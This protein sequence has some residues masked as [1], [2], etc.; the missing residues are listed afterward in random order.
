MF[1]AYMQTLNSF[2]E[3]KKVWKIVVD[4]NN[5]LSKQLFVSHDRI[6]QLESQIY[7]VRVLFDEEKKKRKRSEDNIKFYVSLFDSYL[8]I[9]LLLRSYTVIV[10][11]RNP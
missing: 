10:I 11:Y 3:C 2:E 4:E 5:E 8:P 9:I 1:V 7:D 6:T